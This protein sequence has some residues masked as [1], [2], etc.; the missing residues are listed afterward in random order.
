[1]ETSLLNGLNHEY[2]INKDI[3]GLKPVYFSAL[4]A[5][6]AEYHINKTLAAS[7]TPTA[8]FAL[9]SI[10]KDAPVK[11]YQQSIGLVAGIQI[12]F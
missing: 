1:M 10:N 7:L 4:V 9:T 11:S 8:R 2:T 12:S 5:A 6:S 3:R